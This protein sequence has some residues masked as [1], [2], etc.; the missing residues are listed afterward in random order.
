MQSSKLLL[1]S[2]FPDQTK[3]R[4]LN[5]FLQMMS[6]TVLGEMLDVESSQ[7]FERTE[8]QVITIYKKKTASYSI[9]GPLVVGAL[10]GD[11]PDILLE[12]IK[13][14]GEYLGIAF[15]IQDDILGVFGDQEA[16]GKSTTSDIEE[17]K[18]T[19][20]LTHCLQHASEKQKAILETH[21]G[22]KGITTQQHEAIKKIFQDTGTLDYCK[23]EITKLTS[24]AKEIIPQLS[25]DADKQE[26]LTQFV[27]LLINREK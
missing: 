10:L 11:A 8:E 3:M 9:T 19:L 6:D 26:L 17:N 15:Q 13:R 21:Y 23:N 20:L 22:K 25:K 18:S 12:N 4:A 1:E 5:F 14:F 2:D 27:N 7:S 24:H 16:I